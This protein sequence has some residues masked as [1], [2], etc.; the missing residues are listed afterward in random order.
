MPLK[1]NAFF[2]KTKIKYDTF[3]WGQDGDIVLDPWTI[4]S[5]SV[6]I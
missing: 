6:E 2:K 4:W 3:V 1:N 5:E